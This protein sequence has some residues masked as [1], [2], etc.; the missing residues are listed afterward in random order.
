MTK[1]HDLVFGAQKTDE[2]RMAAHLDQK[3]KMFEWVQVSSSGCLFLGSSFRF[4][5]CDQSS[6]GCG[7]NR[8]DKIAF[9]SSTQRQTH[10]FGQLHAN[11]C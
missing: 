2:P 1:L 3:I 4:A 7:E 6:T 8:V 10:H 11:H 5:F 9:F